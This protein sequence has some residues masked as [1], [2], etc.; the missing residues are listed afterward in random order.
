MRAF[1]CRTQRYKRARATASD[2]LP[3]RVVSKQLDH[4]LRE[5]YWIVGRD[6]HAVAVLYDLRNTSNR[7]GQDRNA[8]AHRLQHRV[9]QSLA[10]R[11]R[12]QK[13]KNLI[14]VGN[15]LLMTQKHHM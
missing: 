7:G 4:S 12:N 13:I 6:Y 2:R 8:E 5:R 10:E 3:E 14:V 15:L 11:R 1:S 9:R